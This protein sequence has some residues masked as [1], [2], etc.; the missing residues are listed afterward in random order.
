[1]HFYSSY[2]KL[3]SYFIEKNQIFF[4]FSQ[5]KKFFEA[6]PTKYIRLMVKF[7]HIVFLQTHTFTLFHMW[8]SNFGHALWGHWKKF[9]FLC[10]PFFL[11]DNMTC[12]LDAIR[13]LFWLNCLKPPM[14]LFI[15]KLV[16][17]EE[18]LSSACAAGQPHW[19]TA[20]TR[21]TDH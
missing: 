4:T 10:F 17:E 12:L 16:Q 18:V 14:C 13:G 20:G 11:S 6:K 21:K 19:L 15:P 7:M 1:M 2:K 5:K 3:I 8:N 9:R